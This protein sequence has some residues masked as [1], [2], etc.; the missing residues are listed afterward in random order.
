MKRLLLIPALLLLSASAAG[1]LT[2]SLLGPD[3]PVNVTTVGN[4]YLP[5]TARVAGGG[6]VVV[7]VDEN[8]SVGI[9]GRLY[10]A[11]GTPAG[12]EL[13][14]APSGTEPRV[15]PTPDGGFA[16]VWTDF[17]FGLHLRRFDAE[18]FLLGGTVDFEALGNE[19]DVAADGAGNLVVVW[20]RAGSVIYTQRFGPN[21]QSLGAPTALSDGSFAIHPRVAANESGA[22]LVTW[23]EAPEGQDRIRTRRYNPGTAAWS[24]AATLPTK[25]TA[26]L[27]WALPVLYAEG[28]GAVVFTE[29]S[30]LLAL[31][32]DA[33]GA[34]VGTALAAGDQAYL[35]HAPDL[36]VDSEGNAFVTWTYAGGLGHDSRVY[37]RLFNRA[38]QALGDAFVV[39]PEAFLSDG[40]P[41]VTALDSDAFAVA[42]ANGD[43]YYADVQV[44]PL[45]PAPGE[46]G[47]VF[48]VFGQ[49]VGSARCAAGSKVLC[50]GVNGRFEARVTW[51]TPAGLTG[52]GRAKPLTGDTGALWFVDGDNLELMVKVLDAGLVNGQYWVFYGSLSNLEYT[53]TVKDTVTQEEKTYHNNQRQLASRADVRAF[54]TLPLVPVG[55]ALPA[56]APPASTGTE[57][58]LAG[59]RFKVEVAFT[60]PRTNTVGQ[61]HAVPLT[62]DTGAFWFFDASNLELMIKVLDGRLVNGHFWVFFGALSDVDYT[63]TVTDSLTGAFQTYHNNR[64]T[65]ASRADV[66]AF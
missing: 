17:S 9:K 43:L 1:A 20:R 3:F 41:A 44:L 18:G 61:G 6:F 22:A 45:P 10:S 46:D 8:N 36:A 5:D 42:W 64:H 28:D 29:D 19:P 26:F 24:P 21:N 37:G 35:G 54:P 58:S 30:N 49:V 55:D 52:V 38:W 56:P 57:L 50:L 4:Q 40:M 11:S 34:P 60:D 48:G 14:L 47:S 16:L 53:L 66:N 12:G 13:T 62:G 39:R 23:V 51:K 15:T 27:Y 31:P 7:W 2:P 32:L 63:I 25:P 33:A 65:L 59:D